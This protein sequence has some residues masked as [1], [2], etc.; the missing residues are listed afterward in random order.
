MKRTL[1]ATNGHLRPYLS[2][3]IPKMMA[4]TDRNISTR[5]IPHVIS[6]FDRSNVSARLVTVNE[7]V[8]KSYPIDLVRSAS[9]KM[10]R[11]KTY[12]KRMS[13][14]R[15]TSHISVSLQL[16]ECVPCPSQK[17]T[18][19]EQPLL[20]TKQPQNSDRILHPIHRRLQRGE[21][22][23]QIP[24]RAHLHRR[25]ASSRKSPIVAMVLFVIG[26]VAAFPV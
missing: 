2:A 19:E 24:P 21:P 16:T 10:R 22:G 5:V 14:L 26:R 6:V 13:V 20:R 7:T 4:P 3:A 23:S 15:P 8:K 17:R 12:C 18:E 25:L 9:V 1:L 11:R